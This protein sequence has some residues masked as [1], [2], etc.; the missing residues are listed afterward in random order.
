MQYQGPYGRP[1]DTQVLLKR[2]NEMWDFIDSPSASTAQPLCD[3]GV[4]WLWVDPSNTE[5]R[6]WAPYATVAFAND[7]AIIL[8]WDSSACG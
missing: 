2:E 7:D 4:E 8:R 1:P 6:D 3:A 5:V